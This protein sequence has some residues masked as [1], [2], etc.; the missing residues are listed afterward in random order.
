MSQ[1]TQLKTRIES[2]A[3]ESK[4]TANGLE[5]F[6]RTFQGHAQEVQTTIGGSAQRKDQEVVQTLQD[7]ARRVREACAALEQAAKVC[8]EYGRSL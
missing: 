8:N 5:T 1:L 4:K 7:A 2:I 3:R 6:Q